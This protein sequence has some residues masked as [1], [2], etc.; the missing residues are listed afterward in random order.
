FY[1][2]TIDGL[3][4]YLTSV[5]KD[6]FG[7]KD[8]YEIKNDQFQPQNIAVLK[9]KINTVEQMPLP[10]DITVTLV[11]SDCGTEEGK[12]LLPRNRDGRFLSTLEACRKYAVIY[13][14]AGEEFYRENIETNCEMGYQEI[15]VSILLRLKDMK[16][17]PFDHYDLVGN[18]R[19]KADKRPIDNAKIQ[20]INPS[21]NE[22]IEEIYTD[23][24]GNFSPKLLVGK[25]LDDTIHY[26]VR[27]SKK[28]YLT[29]IFEINKVLGDTQKI[30]LNY[31]LEKMDIGVDI[32]KVLNLSPINFDLNKSD[33]RPDAKIEL[34]KIV[35]I[36]NDNPT[37]KIELSSHTDCRGSDKYNM[38][39]SQ[40]RAKS[41]AEYI[42]G[43]ITNPER[44]YGKGYGETR[45]LNDCDCKTNTTC[46]EEEHAVNR[47]TE[48]T[49]VKKD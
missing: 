12:D 42:K 1:T 9:G 7:D 10:T 3:T 40:R 45:L 32:G 43:K 22:V 41:S 28:D 39:L 13:K 35:K 44:I 47:R 16:V 6:G 29:Q 30:V 48:F 23:N 26:Q 46:T 5:R 38:A 34:D 11:C 24:S 18:L 20:F 49:I 21:T 15:N 25:S 8:I 27:I 31:E 2:T 37:I 4:G 36:M 14:K 19:Q 33:I 17:I